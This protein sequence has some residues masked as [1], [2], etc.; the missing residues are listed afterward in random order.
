[1]K[2]IENHESARQNQM[3]EE[4]NYN[5]QTENNDL[6][7]SKSLIQ[8]PNAI[9]PIMQNKSEQSTKMENPLNDM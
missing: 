5:N 3:N 7:L 6:T 4:N 1:M 8:Q 2:V 9:S